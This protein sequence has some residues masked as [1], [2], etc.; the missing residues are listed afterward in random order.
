MAKKKVIVS[1]DYEHDRW[2]Y[3]LLKAWDANNHFDFF[4]SDITPKEIQT[5]NITVIKRVLSAKIHEANYMVAL[6]GRHSDE[7]HP[8]YWQIGYNN[9]QAYE[10]SKNLEYGNK[11]VVVKLDKSYSVPLEAYG[12]NAKWVYSFNAEE[13]G[14]ALNSF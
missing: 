4:F 14:T 7:R 12:C 2:Y 11:L 8:N 13:I 6:I 5:S 10:I 1:L 9:W 3:F